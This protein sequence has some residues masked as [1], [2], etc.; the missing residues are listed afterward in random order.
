MGIGGSGLIGPL[1]PSSRG[2]RYILVITD[3]FSKF[4]LTFPLRSATGSA[5]SKHIEE[6]VFLMFGTPRY[7]LCDNGKEFKNKE[8]R[9]LADSYGCEIRFNA[10]YHAQANPT[11]RYNRVVKTMLSC[12]VSDNH[13]L[14]DVYLQAVSCAIRTSRHEVTGESPYF[15]NFGR[16]IALS[17]SPSSEP[18]EGELSVD[19]S[20]N[21]KKRAAE[22]RKMYA[23]VKVRITR[24]YDRYKKNYDLRK[25]SVEFREHQLV[26]RKNFVLSDAA[27]YYAAKLAPKFVGPFV[28]KKKLSPWT[29]ELEDED[30]NPK[31]V[32]HA[33]D[34][35]PAYE[36]PEKDDGG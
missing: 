14:W 32:W 10:H 35:K 27:R 30:G 6:G 17:G 5:V 18:V 24:S 34:L 2:F 7:L 36:D 23:D 11:E 33:K 29:F 15:I 31:G 22:I 13:R 21:F 16:E 9:R 12:Y 25:R 3:I 26:W 19:R 1:P 8:F 20:E 28:I 4:V